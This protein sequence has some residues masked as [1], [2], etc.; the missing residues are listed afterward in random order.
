ILAP[1]GRVLLP[2]ELPFVSDGNE[3]KLTEKTPPVNW[4]Y[5]VIFSDMSI[6]ALS[7]RAWEAVALATAYLNEKHNMPV[8]MCSGE[9]GMPIKLMQSEHL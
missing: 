3:L 8:R 7:T 9:G 5:P 6:G 4:I 2:S 1:F